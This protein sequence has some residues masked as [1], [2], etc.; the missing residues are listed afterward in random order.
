MC[1]LNKRLAVCTCQPGYVGAP[2]A[3]RPECVV[4]SECPMNQAC[5]NQKCTNPC[6]GMCGTNAQCQVINHNPICTCNPGFTGDPF[7]RCLKTE[8]KHLSSCT[9]FLFHV[10]FI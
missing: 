6:P 4:S 5:I 1:R 8:S 7:T 3:C 10:F 2:P 9:F